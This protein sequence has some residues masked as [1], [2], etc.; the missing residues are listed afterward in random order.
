MYN[1]LVNKD[2]TFEGIFFAGVKTTG[3]FCR[4]TCPAKKPKPENVEYFSSAKEALLYGYRPCKVCEPLLLNGEEP[5][6]I[7]NLL[8]ELHQ[9]PHVRIK[10]SDLRDKKLDPVKIARWFKKNMSITFNSYQKSL[11]LVH[12]YGKIR[13]GE[14]VTSAAY[15]SGYESLS[16]FAGLFKKHT[17]FSPVKSIHHHII[18]IIRI[19]TPLGPMCAGA[20]EDGICLLEFA[21]RRMLETQFKRIERIFNAK[22]I[23]GTN[24]HLEKLT[25]QLNEYFNGTRKSFDVQLLLKGT[26]FQTKVWEALQTIPYGST[27]SYQFQAK[28]I[29]NAN[30]VRAVARANGDN[31][32]AIIVPCHRVIGSNGML[33]GYGGGLWRKQ[34]LLDLEKNSLQ[35]SLQMH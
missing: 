7:K 23:P 14:K 20:T 32:I 5:A 29:G 16:G 6:E 1:A 15:D 26:S 19:P 13:Q 8:N 25:S 22:V 4:P 9:A 33:T 24:T 34:Y 35:L 3:I 28:H 30:A 27:A 11:R 17:G 10:A 31:R 12:A 2:S 18:S 21:D